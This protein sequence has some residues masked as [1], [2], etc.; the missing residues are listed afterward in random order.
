[1]VS[2][3][4]HLRQFVLLPGEDVVYIVGLVY[5][6]FL[7]GGHQVLEAVEFTEVLESLIIDK[8]LVFYC[9]VFLKEIQNHGY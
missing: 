9:E 6:L 1:L 5:L 4:E 7:D 8:H 2:D 3:V